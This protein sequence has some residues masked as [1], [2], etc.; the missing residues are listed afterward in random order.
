LPPNLEA[1]GM[2][3]L[4]MAVRYARSVARTP[5]FAQS[6]IFAISNVAVS[7]FAMVSTAALAKTLGPDEFGRY[8]FTVSFVLFAAMFFEF[9]LFLPAARLVAAADASERRTLLGTSLLVFLPVGAAFGVAIVALSYAVDGVFKLDVGHELR[10]IAPLVW[11]YPFT[12]L[13]LQLSQG[14]DRLHTSSITAAVAQAAF[15]V[16]VLA[17]IAIAGSVSLSWAL[18]LRTLAFTAYAVAFVVW[19]GPTFAGAARHVTTILREARAYGLWVYVGRVLSTGTYN[20]DTLMLAAFTDART[21][22]YYVL[23]GTIAYA[24]GLPVMGMATT[25]F[26]RM[27][28]QSRLERRWIWAAWA[29]GVVAALLAWTLATPFLKLVF[30]ERYVAAA[31]LIAP[32]ALAQMVRGVTMVYNSFLSAQARGKEL[33]NASAVLTISNLVL[34]FML[35]PRFG[36]LGAAWA[37]FIALVLNLAAHVAYYRRA[38]GGAP[39]LALA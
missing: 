5:V 22:G 3:A 14:A 9:G 36:A 39:R 20:M 19:I 1:S 30:S 23:A 34:N 18:V 27:T 32:L 2:K 24:S 16:S 28:R 29:I 6:G 4:P 7:L 38:V 13:S 8:S 26:P 15:M 31:A 10:V 21:V 25:L 33:R 11:A 12:Q 37:S 17:A 35:I